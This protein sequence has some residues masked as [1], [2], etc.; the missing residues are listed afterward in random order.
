MNI[1]LKGF[2]ESYELCGKP[3][4]LYKTN[5]ESLFVN[6]LR[7]FAMP[8]RELRTKEYSSNAYQFSID[9][10]SQVSYT[11]LS[12]SEVN[13]KW[14]G[15]QPWRSIG[16]DKTDYELHLGT[17]MKNGLCNVLQHQATETF[18]NDALAKSMRT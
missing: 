18:Q 14:V 10:T 5:F 15:V 13:G 12:F 3:E 2:P 11:S 6:Y 7:G 16:A 4:R 1:K 9:N 17:K 8:G